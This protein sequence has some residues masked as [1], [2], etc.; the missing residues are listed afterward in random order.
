[1]PRKGS[2]NMPPGNTA[3]TAP[4]AQPSEIY[5][6]VRVFVV[7]DHPVV[8]QGLKLLINLE[9]GMAFCGEAEDAAGAL[10]GIVAAEP[11]VAIIDL[12][13]RD[14]SGLELVKDLRIR[15]PELPII[16]LSIH[17]ESLY[18]ER[19]LRAGARG[20]LMK[21]EATSSI[22]AAI[23][24]VL[25]GDLYLSDRMA[26]K[27]LTKYVENPSGTGGTPLELLTDREL[28]IFECIGKG[29]T[30]RQIG[31]KLC[32]SVKTVEAHRENIKRKLNLGGA[33]E[34]LQHAI[35]WV[36]QERSN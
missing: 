5:S 3:S 35:H 18:A 2:P 29:E 25:A 19:V 9:A 21:E 26:R 23:Q 14:S 1:M 12:S 36:Q 15:K 34:L 22:I 11:D 6:K 13:L 20:Y 31:E 28:E 16:V 30:T 27:M 17:D 8:R 33:T 10:T 7:D 4:T 32:I 24:R